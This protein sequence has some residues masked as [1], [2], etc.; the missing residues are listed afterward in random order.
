MK[1]RGF[2]LIE[3]LVVISIISLLS[4]VVL[5]AL[6]SA[7]EKARFAAGKQSSAIIHHALGDLSVAIWELNECSGVPVDSSGVGGNGTFVGSPTYQP[8]TPQGSGCSLSIAVGQ[9]FIVPDNA[10]LDPGLGSATRAFWFKTTQSTVGLF[11]KSDT[12]NTLGMHMLLSSGRLFCGVHDNGTLD[13]TGTKTYNDGKWHFAACVL[14]REA[15]T[16]A[17]YVDGSLEAKTSAAAVSGVNLNSTSV[18][19]FPSPYYDAAYQID[20]IRFYS[21][22]LTAMELGKIYAAGLPRRALASEG[23]LK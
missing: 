17:I 18:V 22:S 21:K 6:N 10:N 2:T 16:L 4:S 19:H 20:G 1:S 11:R 9:G 15:T 8:D 3:L 5:S 7:R 13:I 14:D 12:S 23:S